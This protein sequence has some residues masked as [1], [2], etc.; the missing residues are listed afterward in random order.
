MGKIF[1]RGLERFPNPPIRRVRL[2]GVRAL[3]LQ[4][5]SFS[6]ALGGGAGVALPGKGGR[7]GAGVHRVHPILEEGGVLAL[8][9]IKI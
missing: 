3:A 7:G 6:S 4:S 8:F 1:D 9:L 2:K 5:L